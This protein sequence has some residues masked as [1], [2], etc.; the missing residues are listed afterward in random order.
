MLWVVFLAW[1]ATEA[2]E[3]PQS[4]QQGHL[5]QMLLL[6]SSEVPKSSWSSAWEEECKHGHTYG[7]NIIIIVRTHF[8]ATS[9]LAG[10][11]VSQGSWWLSAGDMTKMLSK[12][13]MCMLAMQ[14]LHLA[15]WRLTHCNR[16][17]MRHRERLRCGRAGVTAAR[18]ELQ[19]G[20]LGGLR[21]RQ[22]QEGPPDWRVLQS[23]TPAALHQAALGLLH[24][25]HQPIPPPVKPRPYSDNAFNAVQMTWLQM[26]LCSA[27]LA[28]AMSRDCK[29]QW[30]PKH[31]FEFTADMLVQEQQEEWCGLRKCSAA[32][33]GL[34]RGEILADGLWAS[35][36]FLNWPWQPGQTGMAMLQTAHRLAAMRSISDGAWKVWRQLMSRS[37]CSLW[38]M[39]PRAL[40]ICVA[41][42]W[43]NSNI[44]RLLG[45][46]PL[47]IGGL[48]TEATKAAIMRDPMRCAVVR[49]VSGPIEHRAYWWGA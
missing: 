37:D 23:A 3:S 43:P 27:Y 1:K 22:A 31:V 15:G 18:A 33:D 13:G 40:T 21:L 32:G 41:P 28:E 34:C 46:S 6:P 5:K 49:K 48:S 16:N 14:T 19:E 38:S 36:C 25:P 35:W 42:H 29:W 9:P 7:I 26:A 45:R 20:L 12:A 39:L 2:P 4:M 8:V 44:K 24:A 10:N 11:G 30:Q 17:W 47:P